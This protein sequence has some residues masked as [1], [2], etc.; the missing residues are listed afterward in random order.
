[1]NPKKALCR[2]QF[3]DAAVRIALLRWHRSGDVERPA[4]AV[5]K[6][7]ERMSYLVVARDEV[8]EFRERCWLEV[9]EDALKLHAEGLRRAFKAHSGADDAL[10]KDKRMSF[11]EFLAFVDAMDLVDADAGF[12]ER[13]ANFAFL[14]AM[15]T[16]TD[17]LAGDAYRRLDFGAFVEALLRVGDAT[18]DDEVDETP[19]DSIADLFA[20]VADVFPSPA[21]RRKRAALA[22]EQERLEKKRE[23]AALKAA[24]EA[25]AEE[26][27]ARKASAAAKSLAGVAAA[28]TATQ[29]AANK[30]LK[31]KKGK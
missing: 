26:A 27:K 25:A 13:D 8:D 18:A 28:V 31:R 10:S 24:K 2:F 6:L 15:R 9:V 7:L 4:A 16:P 22:A 12:T 17:E 19:E 1:M 29:K 5:G 3:L 20:R 21:E 11:P 30:L 23:A 14:R